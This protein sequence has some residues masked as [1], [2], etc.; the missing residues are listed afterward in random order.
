MD[1]ISHIR[2]TDKSVPVF[3]TTGCVSSENKITYL[4]LGANEVFF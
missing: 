3:V 4:A 1:I 2:S